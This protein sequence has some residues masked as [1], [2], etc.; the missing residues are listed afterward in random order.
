MRVRGTVGIRL[1][2]QS[3][4]VIGHHFTMT[5]GNM[6]N[7]MARNLRGYINVYEGAKLTVGDNVGMSSPTLW[8]CSE[9]HIDDNC[10]IGAN[11]IIT[12]TDAHPIDPTER[13]AR[14][15][16]G[17]SKTIIIGRNVFI[18]VNSIIL[19]GVTIGE[20]SVIGA[21]SVVTKNTP[22]Q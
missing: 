3:S 19:K 17:K 10:L 5:S 18:G 16:G 4:C 15:T 21:G 22:P 1:K 6:S 14:P 20:N 8:C 12:D 7:A 2:E 11:V 9:I 13:L